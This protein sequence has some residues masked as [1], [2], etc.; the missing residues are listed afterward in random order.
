[1]FRVQ[2]FDAQFNAKGNVERAAKI[3][4]TFSNPEASHRK[5]TP[6]TRPDFAL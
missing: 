1:M 2:V 4:K 3:V 5:L 6:E